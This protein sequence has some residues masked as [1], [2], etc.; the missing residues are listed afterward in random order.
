MLSDIYA[1]VIDYYI[2]EACSPLGLIRFC[3]DLNSNRVIGK[4][5]KN[6]K[7]ANNWAIVF[8]DLS[9]IIIQFSDSGYTLYKISINNKEDF[10]NYYEQL[11]MVNN[12]DN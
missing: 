9:G 12:L 6:K 2:A 7:D 5:Y 8:F 4:L 10:L 11:D 1:D 3:Y